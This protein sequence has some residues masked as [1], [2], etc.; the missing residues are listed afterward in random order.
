MGDGHVEYVLSKD[1]RARRGSARCE[2]LFHAAACETNHL[3]KLDEVFSSFLYSHLK[4]AELP[5][6]AITAKVNAILSRLTARPPAPQQLPPLLPT[7]YFADALSWETLHVASF[8]PENLIRLVANE[9]AL[10]GLRHRLNLS[11]I[12]TEVATMINVV[13]ERELEQSSY[14]WFIVRA[15]LWALWHRLNILNQYFQCRENIRQ[16]SS[17]YGSEFEPPIPFSVHPGTDIAEFMVRMSREGKADNMC[18]WALELIRNDPM[19]LGLDFR[20]LH[21]RFTSVFHNI[22]TRCRPSST[23]PCDGLGPNCLRYKGTQV[24]D[25]SAHDDSCA[26]HNVGEPK[27]NWEENSY[28]RLHGGKAVSVD[29]KI[30]SDTI[31]QYCTASAKTLAISHVWAHGQGGRPKAGINQCLHQRYCKVARQLRCNSY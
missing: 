15:F 9:V 20:L 24:S 18:S 10:R 5:P 31:L 21:H 22:K 11:D 13:C 28:R 4:S 27:L 1:E 6:E 3:A 14:Q 12:L 26:F 23:Q 25:Q 19:C 8:V 16:G 29:P 2:T 17:S 30:R 7:C